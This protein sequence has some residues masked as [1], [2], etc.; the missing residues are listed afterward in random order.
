MR[1]VSFCLLAGGAEALPPVDGGATMAQMSIG[2]CQRGDRASIQR[3]CDL[4][5]DE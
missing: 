5:G 1:A 4:I 2:V 3:N